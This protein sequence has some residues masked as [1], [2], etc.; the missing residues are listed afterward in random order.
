MKV[1]SVPCTARLLFSRN[2]K[3]SYHDNDDLKAHMEKQRIDSVVWRQILY[4]KNIE[5][6]GSDCIHN[7]LNYTREGRQTVS[8]SCFFGKASCANLKNQA[9]SL[10]VTEA[11]AASDKGVL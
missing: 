7:M 5:R 4:A 6:N 3:L 8:S 11:S 2:E 9:D 10:A 1:S